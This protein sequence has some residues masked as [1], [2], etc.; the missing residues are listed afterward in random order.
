VIVAYLKLMAVKSLLDS[1]DI[2]KKLVIEK[3]QMR[4]KPD[5]NCI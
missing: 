1:E 4:F 5:T 2:T 3:P